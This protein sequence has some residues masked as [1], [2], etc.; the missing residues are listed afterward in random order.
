MLPHGTG[1]TKTVAVFAQGEHAQEAEE[2]GADY[3]GADDLATRVQEG[4]TDFDVA[5]ATPDMMAV[6]GRLGRILGPQGKMPNPRSGT[7]TF[8]I[9]KAVE[10]IKAGKIEYRTENRAGLVHVVIGKQVVRGRRS[11]SRTTRA[12]LEEILRVK[13]ASAKGRYIYTIALASTMGP[14]I[15]VDPSRT[16][17]LL[18]ER[19]VGART[20]VAR[21][22]CHEDH[23]PHAVDSRQPREGRRPAEVERARC[24][25]RLR[26]S[27]STVRQVGTNEREEVEMLK[28]RKEEIVSALTEEFGGVTPMIVADPTGLTVA[29]MKDLRN[30]LRPSGAEF[31]VAKNTLAR[32]A[33][34]EAAA[35]RSSTC[36]SGRRPITLVPGDPA[37][38]AKTLSDFGRTSRKLELRGAY[39]GRRGARR[40]RRQAARDAAVARTAAGQARDRD[41]LADQRVR[42]RARS[43]CR[44]ASSSRSTRSGSR[45][46]RPPRP[47]YPR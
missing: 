10:E 36:S 22:R 46:K 19:G 28:Q 37:A 5:L 7:I 47:H 21:L 41:H 39:S 26:S 34:R 6:V 20:R 27:P 33:A 4:W 2:A 24:G 29:E 45:R 35:R 18:E 25:A 14:G 16:R 23:Q 44:A 3:V 32:I 17:D 40:R 13:P 12:V 9:A 43:S 31:R 30:R 8:D 15:K 1:R 38:A 11:W 42:E